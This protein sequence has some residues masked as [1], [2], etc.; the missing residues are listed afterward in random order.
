MN[1]LA[2]CLDED[3]EKIGEERAAVFLETGVTPAPV[4]NGELAIAEAQGFH[5]ILIIL[6]SAYATIQ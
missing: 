2:M 1:V 4:F 6:G 5:N 3:A